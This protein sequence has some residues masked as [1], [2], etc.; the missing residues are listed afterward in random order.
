M[1]RIKNKAAIRLGIFSVLALLLIGIAVCGSLLAPYDPLASD[2]TAS[3][4]PPDDLHLF[5][6]DKLGRDI[7]SRILC[8][9]GSSFFLTF[10][11]VVLVT[12]IGTL[13][14]LAAGYKGGMT[15]GLL[16]RLMDILLAFPGSVFA[17]AVT[18]I[19]GAG[20]LNTVAALALVWW[21]KYARLVRSM[22]ISLKDRDFVWQ[23][24]YGG[25][26]EIKILLCY[27]LPEVM[28]QVITMAAMD[29]GNMM[30]SLA[31]LSFLGLASQPPA[32]E[33]GYMLYE[34]RQY[35][36]T[37]PWMMIFP[38]LALLVTVMVFNLLG[39]SVRDFLDPKNGT[40]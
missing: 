27:I 33:W 19:I 31:G 20:I 15:D 7:L 5:G 40:E 24:R 34:S 37:A 1:N 21:T 16:M 28:P 18:G 9:A 39:D 8:G 2:Y 25:A 36:Q 26:S 6:T 30:I 14:G 22:T 10:V 35:M 13:V 12:V 38:G 32:P 4:S 23:A 11:M 3:L 17:I 29:I